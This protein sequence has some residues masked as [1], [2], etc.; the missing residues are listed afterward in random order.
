MYA[1]RSQVAELVTARGFGGTGTGVAHATVPTV[2]TGSDTFWMEIVSETMF[3]QP[4]IVSGGTQSV[5]IEAGQSSGTAAG[6]GALVLLPVIVIL[7]AFVRLLLNVNFVNG[8][9]PG[10]TGFFGIRVSFPPG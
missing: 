3:V 8:V 2:E 5:A 1:L 6:W 7:T 4:T 10:L 9:S